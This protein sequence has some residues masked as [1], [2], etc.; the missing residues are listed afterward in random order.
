MTYVTK[1]TLQSGDRV[2]LDETVNDLK[3]FITRKGAELTGPHPRPPTDISVNLHKRLAAHSG[4]FPP[5]SYTVYT[6][7]MEIRGHD[8]LARAIAT[9][10]YPSSIHVRIE[11]DKLGSVR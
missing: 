6:R 7:E 3:Q 2:A 4:Q 1:I 5:W 11:L 9:R 10:S 8:G